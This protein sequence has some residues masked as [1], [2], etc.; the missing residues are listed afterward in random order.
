[1]V[2]HV[3]NLDKKNFWT[4]MPCVSQMPPDCMAPFFCWRPSNMT[5]QLQGEH[6]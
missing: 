3:T 6:G 2:C 1:M 4:Q 5:L